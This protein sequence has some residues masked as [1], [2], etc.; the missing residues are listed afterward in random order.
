MLVHASIV[1]SSHPATRG[2]LALYLRSQGYRGPV[3]TMIRAWMV[4]QMYALHQEADLYSAIIS[5][6]P[7]ERKETAS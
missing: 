6:I 4:D 7:A 2:N 3:Y 1:T 5:Q